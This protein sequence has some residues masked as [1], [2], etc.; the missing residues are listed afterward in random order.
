M[1]GSLLISYH[2]SSPLIRPSMHNK[3][4]ILSGKYLNHF[5]KNHTP[6]FTVNLVNNNNTIHL[7]KFYAKS[8]VRNICNGFIVD[9]KL[10][11]SSRTLMMS[12]IGQKPTKMNNMEEAVKV[13]QKQLTLSKQI[14]DKILEASAFGSL[15]VCHRMLKRFDKSLGFHTQVI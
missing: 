1:G 15:G 3:Q 6:Q 11:S 4:L 7:K 2:Q 12:S 8:A 14:Q 5:L 13:Y 9:N 10:L